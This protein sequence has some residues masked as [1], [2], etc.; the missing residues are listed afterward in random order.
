M[1]NPAYDT[2]SAT[3]TSP[4]EVA[5]T[6]KKADKVVT[7]LKSVVSADGKTLNITSTATDGMGKPTTSMQVYTRQ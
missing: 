6:Y 2:V 5:V 1:G 4:R 7:T 3:E